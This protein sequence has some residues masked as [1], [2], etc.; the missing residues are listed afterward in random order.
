MRVL[1]AALKSGRIA[2]AY[3][4][5]GPHGVGRESTARRFAR[6]LLCS[7]RARP[8][9]LETRCG[10]CP[11]C[12]RGDGALPDLHIVLSEAEAVRRGGVEWG[13]ERKPASDIRV[14]QIRALRDAL[15]L[16]SFA[17]GWR[18][19]LIPHAERLGE[20]A[21][22]ALLKLLEEPRAQ[23]VLLLG[24]PAAKALSP[25]L[26]SRCQR[27]LFAPLPR[28]DLLAR[29]TQARSLTPA[30]AV[31][32]ANASA[33]SLGL[34]LRTDPAALLA[35]CA[36]ATAWLKALDASDLAALV[37][38]A[39]SADKADADPDSV[40]RALARQTLAEAEALLAEAL[41]HAAAAERLRRRVQL[42]SEILRA[43]EALRRPGANIKMGL[44][45]LFL[46]Q[47]LASRASSG[48]H[49]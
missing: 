12:T 21:G 43:R 11:A 5:V 35:A 17:G 22:N 13:E 23:T 9:E 36:S 38:L 37:G 1:H 31:A 48:P 10:I 24:A 25:T 15:A 34:A 3:L 16:T 29:L 26:L 14:D 47:S 42:G 40:L 4:F 44:E 27:V 20:E 8:L 19:A 30:D 6:A 32:I 41:T 46:G 18:V 39:E 33:G 45:A 28:A 2:H 7:G 49:R